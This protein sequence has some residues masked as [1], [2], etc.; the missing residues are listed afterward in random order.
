MAKETYV[1][2]KRDQLCDKENDM[3][4]KRGTHAKEAHTHTHTHTHT[5]L[6]V[7]LLG[8]AQRE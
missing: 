7:F 8:A 2:R 5:A 3:Y 4:R 6:T 1:Y